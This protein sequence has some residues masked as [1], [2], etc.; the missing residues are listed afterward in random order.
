M[1]KLDISYPEE[2][3]DQFEEQNDDIAEKE[4]VNALD[5]N[6]TS[7]TLRNGFKTKRRKQY[8]VIRYVRFNK[9][10]DEETYF[11]EKMLLF[12]PL[13]DENTD[14]LGNHTTYKSHYL[15]LKESID[16]KCTHYK[17]HAD[18]FDLARD[19]AET[20]YDAFDA[21]APSVQQTEAE[22]A[23]DEAIESEAFIHFNPDRIT[24]HREV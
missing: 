2:C 15:S 10:S 19:I 22:T 18:E 1:S 23:Q 12:Y 3:L 20:E 4:N 21:I 8:R 11:R 24:E 7:V 9:T 17:H 6:D 14:L 5:F 13:R 16:V